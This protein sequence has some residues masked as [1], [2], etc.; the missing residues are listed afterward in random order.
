MMDRWVW[1]E[2]FFSVCHI[3]GLRT[4]QARKTTQ[5]LCEKR[6]DDVSFG[7]TFTTLEDDIIPLFHLDVAFGGL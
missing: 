2:Q 1:F 4:P 5:S 3:H 6:M 7:G